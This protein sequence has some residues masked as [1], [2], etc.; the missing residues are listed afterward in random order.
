MKQESEKKIDELEEGINQE[1]KEI[2]VEVENREEPKE[3]SK[4]NHNVVVEKSNEI[5]EKA[6]EKYNKYL[7]ADEKLEEI[8]K[9]FIE[10]ENSI[11]NSTVADSLELLKKLNV[12]SLANEIDTAMQIE[13]DNKEELLKVKTP[14]RGVA[15]GLFVGLLGMSATIASMTIYGAKLANLPLN[16]PTFMQKS[17][18]DTIATKFGELINIHSN[19]IA[20]YALVGASSALVGLILYKLVTWLQKN[21][22]LKYINKLENDVNEYSSNL[23]QKIDDIYSLIAHLENIKSV[24]QKYDIILKEQ[25]AKIRRML[26]IE[27][28]EEG[29]DSLQRASQLEVEKTVL[30]LDE[31]LE[32]MNTPVNHGTKIREE[33]VNNLSGANNVINEVIKKLYI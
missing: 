2:E 20:G 7:A 1:V 15:K 23:E 28:P 32:L 18:L 3:E 17:N 33:S 9:N 4:K 11:I 22:N 26:F 12:D 8:T 25:N 27:Q 19:P 30:I 6:K 14:S 5:K 10:Q 29:V 16:A 13:K 31:L 21:K 24:M